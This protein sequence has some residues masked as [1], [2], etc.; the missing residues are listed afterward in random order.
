MPGQNFPQILAAARAGA[1]WAWAQVYRDLAPAVL[2]YL[3]A[4]G[5][6]EPDDLTGEVFLRSSVTC[7]GSKGPSESFAPGCL[8]S[9]TTA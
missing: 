1:D 3:R 7:P 6:A 5:A 4:R 8:R 9:P 2:G